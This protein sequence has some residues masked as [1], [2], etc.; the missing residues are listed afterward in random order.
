MQTANPNG[1]RLNSLGIY[2]I[3]SL[4]FVFAAMI[5]FAGI[6]FLQRMKN[7][8]EERRDGANGESGQ[9][10]S[11]KMQALSAKIDGVALTVFLL[12]F[13][14]FNVSYGVVYLNID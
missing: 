8:K 9:R 7:V 6:L 1:D 12:T 3:T 13:I 5:E 2:I 10:G 11:F 14:T 4:M